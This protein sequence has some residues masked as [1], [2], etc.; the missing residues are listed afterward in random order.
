MLYDL[1][2][3]KTMKRKTKTKEVWDGIDLNEV[4]TVLPTGRMY[5][6]G[7]ELTEIE[8]KNLQQE[9]QAIKSFRIWEIMQ[10]TV[11]QKAVEKGFI[12]SLSWEQT[13]S[14]KMMLHNLGLLRSIVDVIEKYV[15]LVVTP[16]QKKQ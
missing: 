9:V 11:K 4:I 16:K 7:N 14:G 10:E 3:Q 1:K 6:A 5:I 2:V 8:V 12:E 15:P 13:L